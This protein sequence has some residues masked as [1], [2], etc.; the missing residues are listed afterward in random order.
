M[1]RAQKPLEPSSV[2]NWLSSVIIWPEFTKRQ[3]IIWN[4]TTWIGDKGLL[5]PSDGYCY[6]SC[7]WLIGVAIV[8]RVMHWEVTGIDNALEKK[9]FYTSFFNR[10]LLIAFQW[11]GYEVPCC[12]SRHKSYMKT[13]YMK[14]VQEYYSSVDWLVLVSTPFTYD[15]KKLRHLVQEKFCGFYSKCRS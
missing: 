7:L 6:T 12:S 2:S 8:I 13:C 1:P 9:M 10:T 11:L 4:K 3:V 15:P 5:F 14:I